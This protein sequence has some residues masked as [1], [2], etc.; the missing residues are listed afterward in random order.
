MNSSHAHESEKPTV[1]PDELPIADFDQILVGHIPSRIASLDDAAVSTLIEYE[2]GHARRVQVV[3]LLEHRLEAL[4][5]G[6][7]PSDTEAA[8]LPGSGEGVAGGSKVSPV[9]AG[10]PIDVTDNENTRRT[11]L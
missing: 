2:K 3:Q 5:R 7:E 10:P 1:S 11:N 4:K 6:A 9:T 8:P